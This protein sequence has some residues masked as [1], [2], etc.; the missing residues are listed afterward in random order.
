LSTHGI[1][2]AL[3][4][5]EELARSLGAGAAEDLD[6]YAVDRDRTI[7]PLFDVVDQIAGYGWGPDQVRQH[8]LD[9][10][11]AMSAE[12]RLIAANHRAASEDSTRAASR[13]ADNVV[14]E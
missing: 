7:G 11:S 6:R 9:L 8:L 4:D 12:L 10:N 5:A 2:D 14:Y 1:T 3:R 13:L